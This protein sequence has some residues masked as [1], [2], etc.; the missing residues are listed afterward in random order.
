MSALAAMQPAGLCRDRSDL[1]DSTDPDDHADAKALC[2]ACPVLVACARALAEARTAG[3]YAC[4]VG[5]WAGQLLTGE[6]VHRA[7]YKAWRATA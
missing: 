6:A 5:T 2:A 1:F 3:A 7:Q 4:P